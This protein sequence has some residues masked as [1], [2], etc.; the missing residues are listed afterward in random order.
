MRIRTD[1]W[2]SKIKEAA[3]RFREKYGVDIC[4]AGD[5]AETE[6][7]LLQAKEAPKEEPATDNTP[8][9]S[10]FGASLWGNKDKTEQDPV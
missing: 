2:P 5:L 6:E 3:K 4:D 9:A 8:K 10:G 7:V 1:N